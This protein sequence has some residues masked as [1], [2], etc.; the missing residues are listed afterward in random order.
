MALRAITQQSL[1]HLV[2][3]KEELQ[4]LRENVDY[5]KIDNLSVDDYRRIFVLVTHEK[6][7]TFEDVFH[8]MVMACFLLYCTQLGGFF[9]GDESEDKYVAALD[10][11]VSVII[12]IL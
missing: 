10:I 9:E 5:S 12:M 2:S 8:R 7:R 6:E 11:I 3:M 4:E 1:E